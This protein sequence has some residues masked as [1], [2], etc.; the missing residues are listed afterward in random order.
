MIRLIV[1]QSLNGVIGVGDKL[2]WHIPAEMAHFKKETTLHEATA[3]NVVVMGSNTWDSIP[4]KY[5]P[6]SKRHNV[7]LSNSD[8]DF[9]G[10]THMKSVDEVVKLFGSLD[11]DIIVIGGASIYKQFL[12]ADLVDEVLLTTVD[13]CVEASPLNVY[14]TGFDPE[15][16][17]WVES[18]HHDGFV[19]ER[20]IK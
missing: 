13:R 4:D 10:A 3:Q 5:R 16:F 19:V 18:I 15:N 17:N 14:L 1:A 6:L 7:V 11:L 20:F 9:I 12:E 8:R 2:P